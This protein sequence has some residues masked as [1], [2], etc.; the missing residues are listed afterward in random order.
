[1]GRPRPKGLHAGKPGPVERCRL[2]GPAFRASKERTAFG[3]LQRVGNISRWSMQSASVS[4][5]NIQL[6]HSYTCE[7]KGSVDI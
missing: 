2:Q 5:Y 7:G 4:S 3:N 1:M 6:K